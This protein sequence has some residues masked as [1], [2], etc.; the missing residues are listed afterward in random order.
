[1]SWCLGGKKEKEKKMALIR[2]TWT[3]KEADEWTKED[4]ITVIISPI[5]Y[6]LIT[7]GTALSLLLIPIGF[8]LLGLGIILTLAMVYIINPK[9]A[10]TSEE[11]EKK[12]KQYLDA[13]EK[14]IKWE[15]EE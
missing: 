13:L 12:Q 11:Y 7:V 8:L 1:V 14:K 6:A 9:L 15:E 10:A 3:A 4:T 5:I 2:R